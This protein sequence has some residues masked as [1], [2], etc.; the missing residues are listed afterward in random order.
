MPT[1]NEFAVWARALSDP[2]RVRI[3]SICAERAPNVREIAESLQLSDPLVSHHLKALNA[4]GLL[5][6]E[7]VGR[8]AEYSLP[9]S[10]PAAA[11]LAAAFAA[12]DRNEPQ[13]RADC[14]ALA[15][16]IGDKPSAQSTTREQALES[17]RLE[18]AL[19]EFWE[20]RVGS[21]RQAGD[22][23]TLGTVCVE[24]DSSALVTAA[25]RRADSTIVRARS[26]T[27]AAHLRKVLPALSGADIRVSAGVGLGDEPMFDLIV[28]DRSE[29]T[30][31]DAFVA[32]V[33]AARSRLAEDKSL[34]LFVAYDVLA[35]EQDAEHPLLHLRRLL[36]E[37][38]FHCDRIQPIEVGRWHLLA[39]T[40]TVRANPARRVA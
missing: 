33:A 13:I 27:S 23:E 22:L 29:S 35:G 26:A 24:S 1:I 37:R 19:L 11:W 10:G 5:V 38:E 16:I 30:S 3:V 20:S 4:C 32:D 8:R 9:G 31:R 18:R 28:L 39:A 12:I 25:A 36:S 34:V 6:R 40:A 2:I 14:A 21:T 7:R 15:R 17:Q